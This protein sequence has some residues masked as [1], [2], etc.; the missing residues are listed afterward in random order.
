M[1]DTQP[2]PSAVLENIVGS[3]RTAEQV[4]AHMESSLRRAGFD[5]GLGAYRKMGETLVGQRLWSQAQQNDEINRLYAAVSAR[6]RS[7]YGLLEPYTDLMRQLASLEA[8]GKSEST[9]K[10]IDPLGNK[11]LEILVAGETSVTAIRSRLSAARTD[12]EARLQELEALGRVVP[13]V[14]SGRR[15]Y[16]LA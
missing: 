5:Q 6:A 13:R 1:S 14:A 3:A 12:I 9:S 10:Q 4:L 8:L 11:I 2:V 7:I 15:L 16:R